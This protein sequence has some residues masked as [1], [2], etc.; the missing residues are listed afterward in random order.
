MKCSLKIFF[1]PFKNVVTILS[2]PDTHTQKKVAGWVLPVSHSF[3]NLFLYT[4][5]TKS[6]MAGLADSESL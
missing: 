3:L 2:L 5:L 4:L 6:Q 1:Q